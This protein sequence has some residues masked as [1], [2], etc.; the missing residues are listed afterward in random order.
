MSV[1]TAVV[2]VASRARAAHVYRQRAFVSALHRPRLLRAEAWLDPE[3]PPAD[4]PALHVPPGDHG[5]RV[6]E[7]RNAAAD[8]AITAG[9]EL[10]IFLDA[11]C[12]PG[13]E[14]VDRYVQAAA[15]LPG[16]ILC[17]PVTYLA[18]GVAPAGLAD[19][20]ALTRPHAARPN[21]EPGAIVIAEPADYNL[22]WSLSFAVG[23]ATW[24][25][26]GGF[27]P[28]YQGYGAEDTDF[29]WRARA[30]GIPL[31]WVGGAHAYHQWHPTSAPPW[32]HLDDILRNG[33]TFAA[34]WGEWPMGGWLE[35]FAAAGAIEWDG[36]TWRRVPDPPAS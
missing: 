7:G 2:T 26:S 27:S 21:P 30:A 14:L 6:G 5:L 15:A 29:A 23:A 13:P 19:L 17:G 31:A 22:F 3:P 20:D 25:A 11:D 16:S 34:R 33:A 1:R 18:E 4:P 35:Q 32:Q 12:L 10:L 24:R 8:A 9:A 36:A 28:A